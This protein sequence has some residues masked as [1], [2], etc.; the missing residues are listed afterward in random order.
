MITHRATIFKMAAVLLV[1]AGCDTPIGTMYGTREAYNRDQAAKADCS[2][3]GLQSN[4]KEYASCRAQVNQAGNG[5]APYAPAG[6]G[7]MAPS[8]A[9]TGTGGACYSGSDFAVIRARMLQQELSVIS[10]QCVSADGGRPYESQY[11]SFLGKYQ[12]ALSSNARAFQQLAQRRGLNIDVVIT[13]FA[14]R[15][16]LKAPIDKT[17]CSRG[18]QAMQ[19]ALDPAIQSL[20][21]V[22]LPYDLAPEMNIYQCSA[23]V[24][25]GVISADQCQALGFERGTP[26]YGNCALQLMQIQEAER[27]RQAAEKQRS[28]E[29]GVRMME[30]GLGI[31]SGRQ[32]TAPG[33]ATTPGSTTI[34]R[35]P[36]GRLVTC[37]A[38][39]G[40]MVFCN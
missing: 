21:Q 29:Q 8:A 9:V 1:A 40:N 36:D 17:F 14:N 34:I 35:R 7:A 31:A 13:G 18:V 16:A 4:T 27:A 37:T 2:S 28:R 15:T 23:A 11:K 24:G 20:E 32:S 25:G 3:R 30:A 12:A 33:S 22:P 19:Q 26:A 39:A 6:Q 10:L 5:G 38:G